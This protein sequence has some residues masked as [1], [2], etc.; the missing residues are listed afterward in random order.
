MKLIC[1][2]CDSTL[3]TIEGIDELGRLV[4]E[5]VF[6]KVEE[7]T[8]QA[9][10]GDV[11]VEEVFGRRLELIRPSQQ[12]CDEVGQL[13]VD[14]IVEGVE[15]T[16]TTLYEEG[17]HCVIISGGF[18]E[19]IRPLASRLGIN[20]IHAVGLSFDANGDYAGFDEQSFTSRSGGKPEC[21]EFLKEKYSP[22]KIVM[23]GDGASD[24][25]TAPIVDRFIGYGGVVARE[26]VQADSEFFITDFGEI[27]SLCREV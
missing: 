8:N 27:A 26:K 22:E 13:Y 10:N 21:I 17:W 20:E 5:E 7:L 3:S 18:T 19:A 24:L 12:H 6:A 25:E 1:F 9:M 23:V 14:T 11:P 4:G 15:K 2:D 16:V